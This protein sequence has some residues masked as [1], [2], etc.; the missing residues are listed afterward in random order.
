[1]FVPAV[2][3]LPEDPEV[4]A[5]INDY[6]PRGRHDTSMLPIEAA[7]H[8]LWAA[9]VWYSIKKHWCLEAQRWARAERAR[10]AATESKPPAVER[11]AQ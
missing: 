7:Q 2:G 11:A 9:D 5:W 1:V 3:S 10:E 6:S 4:R 8:V